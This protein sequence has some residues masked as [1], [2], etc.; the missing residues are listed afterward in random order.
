SPGSTMQSKR[1]NAMM[2]KCQPLA[3][4]LAAFGVAILVISGAEPPKTEDQDAALRLR[5]ANLHREAIVIDTHNDIT[6]AVLDSGFELGE[7]GDAPD[8][9]L[10]THTDLRRMQAGGI[11]AEFF[12][13]FVDNRFIASTAA[14]GGGAAR[15]ALDMIDIVFEQVR[16][17]ADVIE[18]AYTV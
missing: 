6:S 16:R 5:A 1:P 15:R 12:A 7:A 9:T 14:Q 4:L 8:R 17:H 13:I 11:S 18:M 2:N 10:K 3:L